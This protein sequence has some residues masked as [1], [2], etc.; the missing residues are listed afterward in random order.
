MAT[1]ENAQRSPEKHLKTH[2]NIKKSEN[3]EKVR[4][5]S[6]GGHAAAGRFGHGRA[7]TTTAAATAAAAVAAAV[8]S[9]VAA[10]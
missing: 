6:S 8:A 3:I 1:P 4:F 2:E 10:A 7:A 9:T 5:C